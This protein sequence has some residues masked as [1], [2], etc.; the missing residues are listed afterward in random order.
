MNSNI[1]KMICVSIVF[2]KVLEIKI[3]MK[4]KNITK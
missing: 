2:I 3:S 1:G 4:L